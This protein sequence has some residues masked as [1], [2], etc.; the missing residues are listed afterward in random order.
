MTAPRLLGGSACPVQG[1]RFWHVGDRATPLRPIGSVV[2]T[3]WRPE[4]DGWARAR[5]RPWVDGG[6][7]ITP[8]HALCT[9]GFSALNW[10]PDEEGRRAVLDRALRLL[11]E[12]STAL[13]MLGLVEGAGLVFLHTDGWRATR[14]RVV[15]LEGCPRGAHLWLASTVVG[16]WPDVPVVALLA[17]RCA[18]APPVP[19]PPAEEVLGQGLFA[20]KPPAAHTADRR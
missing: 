6:E 20:L 17:P 13:C 16:H 15:A 8:A 1:L 14:A 3:A 11:P 9:C 12:T 4:P 19:L 10:P 7:T 18:G 5:C 2:P